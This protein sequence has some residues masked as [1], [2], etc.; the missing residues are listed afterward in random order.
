MQFL[1]DENLTP[2][3][4]RRLRDEGY[5][6]VHVNER[7]LAGAPDHRIWNYAFEKGYVFVT[8]DTGDFLKLAA[9]SDVHCGLILIERGEDFDLPAENQIDLIRA[10]IQKA[11]EASHGMDNTVIRIP[12]RN[13]K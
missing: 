1:I 5:A 12:D 10:G 3:A 7:K 2:R 13:R 9:R 6:A 11:I 8:A 4:A